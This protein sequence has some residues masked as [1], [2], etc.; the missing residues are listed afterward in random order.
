MATALQAL[1]PRRLPPRPRPAA[2]PPDSWMYS[3]DGQLKA[4]YRFSSCATRTGAVPP[5]AT[6][7]APHMKEWKQITEA[8][9]LQP[10]NL[11]RKRFYVMDQQRRGPSFLE[12]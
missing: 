6:G 5:T 2:A 3:S 8:D 1:P 7:W 4:R 10:R 11:S 12:S 9:G